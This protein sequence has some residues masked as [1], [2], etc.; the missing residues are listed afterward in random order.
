MENFNNF[1]YLSDIVYIT[2]NPYVSLCMAGK[3]YKIIS[4]WKNS[5]NGKF[6]TIMPNSV[7]KATLKIFKKFNRKKRLIIHF[8]QPHEPFIFLKLKYNTIGDTGI[9]NLRKSA[10]EK[11]ALKSDV[12][13]WQLFKAGKISLDEIIEGYRQNLKIVMPYVVNLCKILNGKVIITSDHGEAFGEKL[14]PL[15]P[16]KVYGHPYSRLRITPIVKVPWFITEGKND[17]KLLESELIKLS[18]KEKVS[19][20]TV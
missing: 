12:S 18:V 2:A 1:D 17:R 3:F 6:Q 8:M 10:I 19:K 11:D 15:M 13:V 16:I 20:V 5:W 4:V 9:Y 14:H 7:Y